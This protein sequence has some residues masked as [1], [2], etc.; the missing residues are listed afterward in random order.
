[1]T[2]IQTNKTSIKKTFERFR[3]LLKKDY[4]EIEIR[5]V[6]ENEIGLQIKRSGF[7]IGVFSPEN[8]HFEIDRACSFLSLIG[9]QWMT[10][11]EKEQKTVV[12]FLQTWK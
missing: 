6:H 8:N 9:A 11:L 3:S 5:Q 7:Y 4:P 10:I 2:I 1:M 12:Y